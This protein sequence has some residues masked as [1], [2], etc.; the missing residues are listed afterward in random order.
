MDTERALAEKDLEIARLRAELEEERERA[1][2]FE[3]EARHDG[4]TGA[5][6]RKGFEAQV[7]SSKREGH[8]GFALAAVDLDKF[9]TLNDV[10]GHAVGDEALKRFVEV[11]RDTIRSTDTVSRFG[12]EE[13]FVL[14]PGATPEEGAA[15]MKKVAQALSERPLRLKDGREL[16]FTFSCGVTEWKDGEHFEEASSR[17]D[18]LLYAAKESGRNR[19]FQD[20][21]EEARLAMEKSRGVAGEASPA[22][23]AGGTCLACVRAGREGA[24]GFLAAR[25]KA[26]LTQMPEKGGLAERLSSMRYSEGP[27]EAETAAVAKNKIRE[28]L[29]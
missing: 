14:L 8:K 21:S 11:A 19:V 28:S 18:A 23:E 22:S 26:S 4:L 5:P 29:S 17:A 6:N 13:F 9:K 25:E 16:S 7:H 2:R 3:M 15:V 12:G 20:G 10:F 24:E 1:R 27:F